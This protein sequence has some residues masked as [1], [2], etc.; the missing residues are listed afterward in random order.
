MPNDT[1]KCPNFFEKKNHGA[2]KGPAKFFQVL[3]RVSVF[4]KCALKKLMTFSTAFSRTRRGDS[5]YDDTSCS[6]VPVVTI[7]VMLDLFNLK[8]HVKSGTKKITV[9]NS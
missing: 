3:T 9:S 1:L 2:L 4:S 8:L 6:S 5:S 7:L